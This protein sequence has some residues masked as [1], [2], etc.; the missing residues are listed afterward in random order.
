MLWVDGS[1][2]WQGEEGFTVQE[3]ARTG[4]GWVGNGQCGA[5]L[6]HTRC[7]LPF[8][9]PRPSFFSFFHCILLSLFSCP[10]KALLSLI[11]FFFIVHVCP[12]WTRHGRLCNIK[13]VW[14]AQLWWAAPLIILAARM[15]TCW[16]AYH[17][18]YVTCVSL[19]GWW[20]EMR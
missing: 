2:R 3:R 4:R 5:F 12:L 9:S 14:T 10:K 15:I 18:M 1:V 20:C 17:L 19:C 7:V 8:K 11:F 6:L 16:K 13:K